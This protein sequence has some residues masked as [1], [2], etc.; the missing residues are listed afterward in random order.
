MSVRA[1]GVLILLAAILLLS[2]PTDAWAYIDP[3]TTNYVL[4]LL[5]A[6]GMAGAYMVRRYWFAVRSWFTRG[7]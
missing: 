4:Q 1:D 6:V 7:K 3:S 5:V 2:N